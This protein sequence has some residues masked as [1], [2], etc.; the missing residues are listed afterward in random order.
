MGLMIKNRLSRRSVAIDSI[1][2]RDKAGDKG[3]GNGRGGRGE[4]ACL[5]YQVNRWGQ[6]A[7]LDVPRVR[8]VLDLSKCIYVYVDTCDR[9]GSNI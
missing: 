9:P 5:G 7:L 4:S 2:M 6:E 1:D 8:C 3:D